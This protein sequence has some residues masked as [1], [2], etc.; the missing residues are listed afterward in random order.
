MKN[1]IL[2]LIQ[3]TKL[4]LQ[5]DIWLLDPSEDKTDQWKQRGLWFSR[6]SYLTYRR[7]KQARCLIRASSLTTVTIISIVPVLA[8]I[9]SVSKGFGFHDHL[10]YQIIEPTLNESMGMDNAPD[11]KSAVDQIFVF[12]DNTDLSNL[13]MLGFVTIIYAVLRLLSSVEESFNALWQVPSGRTF[14]RKVSDYLSVVLIV[15]FVLFLTATLSTALK[16]GPFIEWV[17]DSLSL[18]MLATWGLQ[19][20]LLPIVWVAFGIMYRLMP[21]THIKFRSSLYGGIFGGTI[22]IVIHYIHIYLQLGVANYNALYAGFSAFPIFIVWILFSWTAILLGAAFAAAAQ[23]EDLYREQVIRDNLRY[24]DREWLI[25]RFTAVL[26]RYF[27]EDKGAV[28]YKEIHHQLNECQ[29]VI[30]AIAADLRAANIV[31]ETKEGKYVLTRSP[32]RLRV[33]DVIDCLKGTARPIL[34]AEPDTEAFQ[35]QNQ[36][37]QLLRTERFINTA[38][39]H[40][41]S[42]N[43]AERTAI[44]ELRRLGLIT[45][46]EGQLIPTEALQVKWILENITHAQEDSQ[47]NLRMD[48]LA[49]SIELNEINRTF[50]LLLADK[51]PENA[52]G[53][54]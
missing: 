45:E 51:Q 39:Y 44:S 4:F 48:Q 32:T 11:L 21:N 15:P 8:F 16:L 9:F 38:D 20:A 42:A 10:R 35:T 26:S 40:S 23:N 18:G 25:L 22:W 36:I 6:I 13:G 29:V 27:L 46:E 43:P 7:F 2:L 3:Q 12:V 14:A 50:E 37:I 41:M 19:L 24:R 33:L 49:R 54:T 30:Q 1:R 47:T 34:E 31:E 17:A 5:K 28:S 53:T 52:F